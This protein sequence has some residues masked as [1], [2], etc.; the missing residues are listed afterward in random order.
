MVKIISHRSNGVFRLLLVAVVS[1]NDTKKRMKKIPGIDF[2]LNRLMSVT[3][4]F[5]W[6][7]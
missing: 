4:L 1:I 6:P 5:K 3:S 7:S 2:P